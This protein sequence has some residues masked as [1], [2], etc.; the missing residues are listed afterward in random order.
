MSVSF[1]L[2]P[3]LEML[4]DVVARFVA[5]KIRPAEDALGPEAT[6]LPQRVV[7]DL[8]RQAR[9]TG[10]WYFDTPTDLGGN[11]LSAFESVVIWEAATRH[12]FCFPTIGGGAFGFTPPFVLFQGSPEQIDR[13]VRPAVEHGW[14]TF[15]SI[16]EATG[17]T[18]V[19]RAIRTTATR[20]GDKWVLN[21][22]KMWATNADR[23][24]F[25]VVY[26]RSEEGISCF[27]LEPDAPGVRLS[28][29]HVIR[30]N[31][32]NLL[33]LDN[34]VLDS[35]HLVGEAGRGLGVASSWLQR[36]RLMIAARSV[37]LAEAAVA[38]AVEWVNSRETFGALLATRQAVQ[39]AIADSR[40]EIEA[41]RMLTWHAA[42]QHDNSRDARRDIAIAKLYASEM[43]FRVVDRMMQLHGAMGMARELP[44][45]GWLR[46][47]RV[48]RV[49]E[50]SSEIL[51]SQIARTEI[52]PAV[53]G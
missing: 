51:R 37:G 8:Q 39:F 11:G 44:L 13:W 25:G 2:D 34:V 21:G 3:E 22:T 6:G 32:T 35:D 43:A 53:R 38:M 46:E 33:E 49:A 24:T 4:R 5:E 26:A 19:A 31:P 14:V 27:V 29:I 18:D 48:Y 17:G 47:L 30:D 36:G 16:A 12:R 9:E 52:G 42:W 45:E 20:D 50:G 41:A 7:E 23:A 15:N 40:V 1:E 10:L 28:P